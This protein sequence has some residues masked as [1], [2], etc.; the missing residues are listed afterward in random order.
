MCGFPAA[1][2]LWGMAGEKDERKLGKKL[3]EEEYQRI[4]SEKASL[5]EMRVEDL[6]LTHDQEWMGT[7][8]DIAYLPLLFVDNTDF[9]A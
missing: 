1:L 8:S 6:E 9:A 3:Q 2:C 7:G 4:M 5:L